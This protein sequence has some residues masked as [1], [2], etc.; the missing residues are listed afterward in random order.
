MTGHPSVQPPVTPPLTAADLARRDQLAAR[1]DTLT[2]GITAWSLAVAVTPEPLA[3]VYRLALAA[4]TSAFDA[5]HVQ[6]VD[7]MAGQGV[8]RSSVV[9]DHG[10]GVAEV[11][12]ALDE[13]DG[14]RP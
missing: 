6:I 11:L 3:S 8:A 4:W 5:L 1:W 7:L 2:D 10:G 14:D 9:V 12:V 13:R